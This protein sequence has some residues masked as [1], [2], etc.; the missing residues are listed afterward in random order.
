[1]D[2]FKFKTVLKLTNKQ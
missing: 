2:Y 1:M